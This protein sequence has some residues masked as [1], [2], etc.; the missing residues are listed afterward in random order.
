MVTHVKVIAVLFILFGALG[1]IGAL[2][3]GLVFG[4][5]AGLIG[6]SGEEDAPGVAAM[7]GLIGTVLTVALAVLSVP[8]IVCGVGLL[9]FRPWARILGIILAIIALIQIPLGTIFG[10][11]AL[12][13]LFRNDVEA[14]FAA[15]PPT[16]PNVKVVN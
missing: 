1:L 8:N 14:L 11:Y 10:V 5:I 9:K 12:I 6:V 13:I 2:F 7:I 4:S 15:A 16:V 3:S